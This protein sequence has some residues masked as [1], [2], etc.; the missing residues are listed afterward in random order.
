MLQEL[1]GIQLSTAQLNLYLHYPSLE[2][3]KILAFVVR[4]KSSTNSF[5]NAFTICAPGT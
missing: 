2:R 1:H 5:C 4:T 3:R